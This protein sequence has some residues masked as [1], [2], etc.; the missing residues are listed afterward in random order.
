MGLL[1]DTG[2]ARSPLR[3]FVEVDRATMGPERLTAKLSAYERLHRYVPVVPGRWPTLQDRAW[4]SGG[5]ATRSFLRAL[6]VLDATGPA[7]VED[8]ITALRAAA[9]S[10]RLRLSNCWI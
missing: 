1:R 7:G 8:R 3:A 4:R 6:L 2:R 10:W 5:G 9:R